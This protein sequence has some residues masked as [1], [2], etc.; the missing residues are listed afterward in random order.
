[1]MSDLKLEIFIDERL[2]KVTVEYDGAEG[3]GM[4]KEDMTG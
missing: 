2:R 3:A 1:M 4:L